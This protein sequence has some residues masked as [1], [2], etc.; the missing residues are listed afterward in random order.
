MDFGDKLPSEAFKE[1]RLV[2]FVD[3]T[4]GLKLRHDSGVDGIAWEGDYTHS[5]STWP[6]SPEVLSESLQTAEVPDDEVQKITWENAARFYDFD[7]FQSVPKEQA[8][9]GQLR[10]QAT[11]VDTTPRRPTSRSSQ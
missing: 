11:D 10:A 2:C 4:T 6:R 1:R 5:D 3:D 8:T 9:V 7:P